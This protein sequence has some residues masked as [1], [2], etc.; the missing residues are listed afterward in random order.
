MTNP[1]PNER[2]RATQ[3]LMRRYNDARTRVLDYVQDDFR[4]PEVHQRFDAV[5]DHIVQAIRATST[6]ADEDM[7]AYRNR[8]ADI[9]KDHFFV[10][11]NSVAEDG[12]EVDEQIAEAI[13]GAERDILG[14]F[15]PVELWQDPGAEMEAAEKLGISVESRR[16][17]SGYESRWVCTTCR[18]TGEWTADIGFRRLDLEHARWHVASSGS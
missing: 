18:K 11:W 13:N 16:T 1:P 8:L 14:E 17:P 15:T 4:E 12:Y 9:M 10:S 2:E 6:A 7:K 5:I 3:I